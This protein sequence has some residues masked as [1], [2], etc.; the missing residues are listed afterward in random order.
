MYLDACALLLELFD[1]ALSLPTTTTPSETQPERGEGESGA[2][3]T[4]ASDGDHKIGPYRVSIH[5]LLR[6]IHRDWAGELERAGQQESAAKSFLAAGDIA[7]A[8]RCLRR[9]KG[10][11]AA[12]LTVEIAAMAVSAGEP[13][14]LEN[15]VMEVISL[16][17]NA[18]SYL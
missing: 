17:L 1:G 13:M 15:I 3:S 9:R 4:L 5:P 12:L 6:K 16:G 8:L 14:S 7:S 11:T 10:R 18:A 2:A